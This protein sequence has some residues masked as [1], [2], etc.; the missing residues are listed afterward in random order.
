MTNDDKEYLESVVKGVIKGMVGD[1]P[2]KLYNELLNPLMIKLGKAFGILGDVPVGISNLIAFPFQEGIEELKF[3][4]EKK[5]LIRKHNFQ[6]TTKQLNA[7]PEEKIVEIPSEILIP[8]IERFSYTSKEELS[9]AFINLLTKASSKDT[10]D[11]AHPSFIHIIDRLS[12]D[13]ARILQYFG[14][15]N[16]LLVLVSGEHKTVVKSTGDMTDENN[17]LFRMANILRDIEKY[18]SISF[19][20]DRELKDKMKLD[21]HNKAEFYYVNLLSLGLIEFV[22]DYTDSEIKYID[23]V[24]EETKNGY[25]PKQYEKE[26]ELIDKARIEYH[27]RFYTSYK[28]YRLTVYGELFVNTCME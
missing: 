5:N 13:E 28:T 23:E 4:R 24:I 19:E 18:T 11:M 26:N 22:K 20:A 25:N 7:I 17:T 16:N 3:I 2:D 15:N 12:S 27:S 10:M 1:V 8:V 21:F 9:N 14:N 6:K